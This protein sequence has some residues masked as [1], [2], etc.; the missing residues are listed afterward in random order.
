MKKI[1]SVALML[2][3]CLTLS[4]QEESTEVK[5]E[6][7]FK[8]SFNLGTTLGDNITKDSY[9]LNLGVDFNYFFNLTDDIMVGPVTGVKYLFEADDPGILARQGSEYL[10]T[11]GGAARLYTDNDKFYFGGDA[12]YAVGL[13]DGG[14]YYRPM[15]GISVSDCSGFYVSYSYVDDKYEF[16]SLNFGY[17]ITF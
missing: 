5:L 1:L 6:D 2:L 8:V 12:G 4:A 16:T 7:Q 15:A 9:S 13:I 11:V 14:Y 17:E 10:I 3:F